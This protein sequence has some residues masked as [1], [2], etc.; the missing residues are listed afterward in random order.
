MVKFNSNKVQDLLSSSADLSTIA[1]S[2]K[3]QDDTPFV[4]SDT[5]RLLK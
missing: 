2:G 3:L 4:G 5:I 1:L